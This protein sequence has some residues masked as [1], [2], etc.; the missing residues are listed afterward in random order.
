MAMKI[1]NKESRRKEN[2]DNAED[3]ESEMA[4]RWNRDV[5]SLWVIE[6]VF[7]DLF[8]HNKKIYHQWWVFAYEFYKE[9]FMHFFSVLYL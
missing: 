7:D 6:V 8:L 3:Y 4:K 1:M 9:F 2:D 5:N